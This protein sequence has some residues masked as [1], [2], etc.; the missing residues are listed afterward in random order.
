MRTKAKSSA[1]SFAR[2]GVTVRKCGGKGGK[3]GPC[4]IE[5]SEL[6][7]REGR[8]FE[9]I[10]TAMG[11]KKP[12]MGPQGAERVRKWLNKDPAGKVVFALLNVDGAETGYDDNGF[13][14]RGMDA[15]RAAIDGRFTKEELD[16][17]SKWLLDTYGGNSDLRHVNQYRWLRGTVMT[18][19]PK[20][21]AGVLKDA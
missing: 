9:S 12:V 4:P 17:A 8:Q 10:Q 11:T 19:K 3:P 5:D 16:A 15:F 18:A 2:W 21:S 20:D 14:N 13:A 7:K 6:F 1:A